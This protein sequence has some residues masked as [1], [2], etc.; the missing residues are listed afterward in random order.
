MRKSTMQKIAAVS[1]T[2]AMAL[3]LTACGGS[4]NE[5]AAA[6]NN[7]GNSAT[8]T[9]AAAAKVETT[10]ETI[11]ILAQSSSEANVNILRDQLTKAGFEVILNLQPDYASATAQQQAGNFDINLTGWTT[12]TGNVD[13]AVRGIFHSTG[14]YNYGPIVDEKIDEL[15]DLGASQTSAQAAETY[16]E[17]E[18]YLVTEKAYFLPLY[19][20]TK[21]QAYYKELLKEESVYHPKSRPGRWEMYDYIDAAN[22][23]TRTLT[24][25]QTFATPS[26][27]DPIQ[28]NDGTMNTLSGN[29]Y[30]KIINLSDD[31]EIMTDSSLSHSYAIGEGNDTYY[32]LLRDDVHY[33]KVENGAVVD[34]GVLV[35]ADDVVYSLERASNKDS[36][37][38]HKTYTLHNHMK[39]IEIV[40]DM[41]ELETVK[42]SDTGAAII[43]TLNKGVS[44]PIASL[45]AVDEEVDNAAGSY[46]VIKVTTTEPF[47]QV[48]NY[49]AHQS[50]GILNKEQ[51]ESYNSKF[52]VASYDPQKDVCY[53]DFAAVKGGDTSMLWSSGPY[54]F[55][56]VD[57]YG[58]DFVKNPGYMPEDEEF[59]PNINSIYMKFIKDTTSATSAFRAG[60]VDLLGSVGTSD[61][62]TL[63]AD[64]KFTVMSRASN[65]V[66]YAYFNLR[67]GNKYQDEDL[68][69]AVL[70]AINQQDFIDY[71]NGLVMPVYSTVGTL[72]ETGNVLVQDLAKSNEYLAAYQAK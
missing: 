25:T 54:Q 18:D 21:T 24:L 23:D 65:G 41:A 30:V 43:E 15:I 67:E 40:T 70:Y 10:P 4:S 58:I 32:F 50:A 27:L 36:V 8:E 20:S 39:S 55:V 6:G 31:D 51:V 9:T 1:L 38:T 68:R 12:V 53:G 29:M 72:V 57:D 44:T 26:S 47:P 52:E 5:T 66:T 45:T 34:T 49:L 7:G 19:C 60:E 48:L 62:E 14:D 16:K 17:F 59:S 3:S 37:A 28:A 71:N 63:Q 69:K 11:Q 42:D 61:V 13:Y 35:A 33:S 56:S 2:A 64:S 46:Q 22:N